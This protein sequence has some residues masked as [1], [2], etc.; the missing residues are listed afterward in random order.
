MCIRDRKR[1]EH[2]LRELL[3]QE[4]ISKSDKES[5]TAELV[6]VKWKINAHKN[7]HQVSTWDGY[8]DHIAQQIDTARVQ[9]GIAVSWS[10]VKSVLQDLRDSNWDIASLWSGQNTLMQASIALQ[11]L[12]VKDKHSFQN[13]WY[14]FQ[15]YAQFV[16][17]LYDLSLI[18][19]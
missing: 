15:S 6:E 13:L 11:L 19:I 2:D 1:R 8:F 18:H 3:A 7:T 12:N 16:S 10:D 17:S 5:Y 9:T 4:G 14:S